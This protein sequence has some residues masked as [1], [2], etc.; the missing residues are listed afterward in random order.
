M[1]IYPRLQCQ[2]YFKLTLDSFE[3]FYFFYYVFN[4]VKKNLTFCFAE[5]RFPFFIL[6]LM[7]KIVW[8]ETELK[9]FSFPQ[10]SESEQNITENSK[11]SVTQDKASD[12]ECFS[13][14]S[15]SLLVSWY[16]LVFKLKEKFPLLGTSVIHEKTLPYGQ[17]QIQISFHQNWL[18]CTHTCKTQKYLHI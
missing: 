11:T 6:R 2:L 10:C 4:F 16:H 12:C 18:Q 7:T 17:N 3:A 15:K 13:R 8:T 9:P 5:R 1:K 14:S